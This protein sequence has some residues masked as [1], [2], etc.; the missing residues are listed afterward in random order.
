MAL[1]SALTC[2]LLYWHEC[3]A[4]LLLLSCSHNPWETTVSLWVVSKSQGWAVLSS[5]PAP[6]F[7]NDFKDEYGSCPSIFYEC[8]CWT[9]M[10][11]VLTVK[12][13]LCRTVLSSFESLFVLF[14]GTDCRVKWLRFQKQKI[15]TPFSLYYPSTPP[16]IGAGWKALHLGC[17]FSCTVHIRVQMTST[18]SSFHKP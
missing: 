8:I 2:N 14:F 17:H 7:V 9:L 10:T 3:S 5:G 16:V 1:L 4:V 18:P 11:S 6:A 15:Y 13:A 12:Y